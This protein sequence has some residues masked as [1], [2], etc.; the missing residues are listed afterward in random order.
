VEL[1]NQQCQA[2]P[3]NN[4]LVSQNATAFTLPLS[5]QPQRHRRAQTIAEELRNLMTNGSLAV[6]QKL[7]TE[8][9]LCQQFQVSRTTLREA[10]QMLRSIGLLDVTPGRGSYV[11]APSLSMLLPAICMAGQHK[12]INPHAVQQQL[13][14]LVQQALLN[15]TQHARLREPIQQLYQYTLVRH[16]EAS[17]CTTQEAAWWG[18]LLALAEQPLLN[19]MG[20]LL[21]NLGAGMR[22]QHYLQQGPDACLRTIQLQL[23]VNAMLLEGDFTGAARCFN[24]PNLP[25]QIAT[26]QAA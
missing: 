24:T 21:I 19:F 23:R 20:Q 16:A 8:T 18:A 2:N 13:A 17:I 26:Q 1:K 12:N 15:S 22:H 25:V 6:G 5:Q 7:P 10:I 11:R 14:L 3:M 9:V 4:N